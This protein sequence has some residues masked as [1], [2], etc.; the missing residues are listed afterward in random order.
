MSTAVNVDAVSKRFRLYQERNQSLK[1]TL[2][3][4]GRSRYEEHWALRGVSLEIPSGQTFGFIGENGSGKSTLLKCIAKIL[5]PDEGSISVE[6]KISALLELGAGF[7]PELSGRENVYLNGSIL[8]LGRKEL[9]RKFDDIVAF[10][11]LQRFIDSP[12]KNYSS[13]M[14]VRLGFS[15]AINVG[16]DVLLVDEVLAVGDEQFQRKCNE[17]FLQLKDDG[18]T[19]VIVTHDLGSVR[20]LCDAV[21]WI[22]QGRL[23][24]V[25]PADEVVDSYLDHVRVE[26]ADESGRGSRWGSGEILVERFELLD[27]SGQPVTRV[28]TGDAVTFRL[29]YVPSQPVE[30]PTFA[31]AV[32]TLE[33][34][35]V[36]RP[37]TR[38]CGS[39]PGR[40][41][42]A[43]VVDLCVERLL[44]LPGTYDA[45]AA[46]T[47]HA[48]VHT[49]DHRQRAFRFDVDPG[50]PHET[51]GGLVSLG[52]R[53]RIRPRESGG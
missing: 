21:G 11:G 23:R 6:G 27:A 28:R 41:E 7:H 38:Q 51:N 45:S 31:M 32:H 15:V 52:G 33:G 5:R 4:R 53:W 46:V 13:G 26:R 3:R 36:T 20:A 39:G 40:V 16:P 24:E 1:A 10:A 14:Y 2:M 22:D 18:I 8:G 17:K 9:D 29:H 42:G 50:D 47:D 25:G 12:V 37:N 34:V 48:G 44:L 19:I 43:G 49:F 30:A 35:E